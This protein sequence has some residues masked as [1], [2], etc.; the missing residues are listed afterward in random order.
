MSLSIEDILNHDMPFPVI[1]VDDKDPSTHPYQTQC[2]RK[3]M[4]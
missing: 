3:F 2:L 1:I 4:D